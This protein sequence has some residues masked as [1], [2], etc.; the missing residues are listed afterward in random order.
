MIAGRP[1]ATRAIFTA[2]SM[3][4]ALREVDVAAPLSVPQLG[5]ARLRGEDGGCVRDA[6]RQCRGASLGQIGCARHATAC[7]IT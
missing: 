7:Q 2:F 3:A 4:S 5:V 1:V 6:S